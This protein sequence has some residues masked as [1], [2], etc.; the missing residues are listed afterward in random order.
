MAITLQKLRRRQSA[1]FF[2]NQFDS[3]LS[4][5]CRYA[6]TMKW[7]LP[8]SHATRHSKCF[9]KLY[10]IHNLRL[11]EIQS[12][13]QLV[14]QNHSVQPLCIKIYNNVFHSF[15]VNLQFLEVLNFFQTTL[16]KYKVSK[17]S[18]DNHTFPSCCQDKIWTPK[19]RKKTY[20]KFRQPVP[21]WY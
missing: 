15:F 16:Y 8:L 17:L 20:P 1:D 11:H 18:K 7:L 2:L 19:K 13:S 3:G 9:S 4:L 5:L 10:F 12:G 14:Q 21:W 6:R